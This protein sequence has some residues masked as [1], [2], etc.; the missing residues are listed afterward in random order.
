MEIRAEFDNPVKAKQAKAA[1]EALGAPSLGISSSSQESGTTTT[2]AVGDGKRNGFF[3]ALAGLFGGGGKSS[4]GVSAGK[5]FGSSKS[6][7]KEWSFGGGQPQD[8]G[9]VHQSFSGAHRTVMTV[10]I[11]DAYADRARD[12]LRAAGGTL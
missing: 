12:A 9:V 3:N 4:V 7:S 2:V 10:R 6:M 5:S 8:D 11:D 1:L